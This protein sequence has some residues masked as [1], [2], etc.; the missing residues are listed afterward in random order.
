MDD[1]ELESRLRAR[2][3]RPRDAAFTQRVLDAL[4]QRSHG[5]LR[6]GWAE[7]LVLTTRVAFLL[8]LIAVGQHWLGA[9]PDRVTAVLTFLLVAVPAI[10]ALTRLCGPL[11]PGGLSRF[12]RRLPRNW[13]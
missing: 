12:V 7:S 5:R 8:A 13:H 9:R 4:P 10:S 6:N 2:A 11:I 1:Q 3:L